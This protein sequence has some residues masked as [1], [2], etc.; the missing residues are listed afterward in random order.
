MHAQWD[1]NPQSPDQKSDALSIRP[2][3]LLVSTFAFVLVYNTTSVHQNLPFFIS[4]VLQN[5]SH[6]TFIIFGRG[7]Y[8]PL[9]HSY[10]HFIIKLIY[11]TRTHNPL[12]FSNHFPLHFLKSV[13]DQSR[14]NFCPSIDTLHRLISVLRFKFA[15]VFHLINC[16]QSCFWRTVSAC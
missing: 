1:S 5:L 9:T 2:W 3:A 4:S 11:K 15:K 6:F 16:V 7:P 8:I 13:P 14:I 10:S 12:T